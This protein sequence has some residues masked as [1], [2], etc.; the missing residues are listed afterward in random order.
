MP[1]WPDTRLRVEAAA[2]AGRP[3]SFQLVW[4]WTTPARMTQASA[5]TVMRGLFVAGT[6]LT[7][8]LMVGAVALVRY[9]LK[10]GRADRQG[11]AR[12]SFFLLGV[13]AA[14]WVLGARH[15]FAL[16]VEVNLFFMAVALAL[17]NVGFTWLFYLGLEPFVRRF[18]PDMLI[19]W[20]RLFR[21]Q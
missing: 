6:L 18:C 12:I 4:P 1:G 7:I 5:S 17:L 10:S 15:S 21:G 20:T 3:V 2:Y 13:W 19:G 8:V 11:A 14:S 16:D 9:N